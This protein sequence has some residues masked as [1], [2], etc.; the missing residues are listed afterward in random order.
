[1]SPR[2]TPT[3]GGSTS[4]MDQLAPVPISFP[5][6]IELFV[7]LSSASTC[8]TILG[9]LTMVGAE[10]DGGDWVRKEWSVC[11]SKTSGGYTRIQ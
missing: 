3:E 7:T 5:S 8:A 2:F 6:G 10:A 4:R 9:V 1:M 11:I